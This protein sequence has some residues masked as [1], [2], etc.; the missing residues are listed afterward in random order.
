MVLTFCAVWAFM[1]GCTETIMSFVKPRFTNAD[2]VL[3]WCAGGI[4][5]F[6]SCKTMTVRVLHSDLKVI[7]V[8]LYKW[9]IPSVFWYFTH[10]FYHSFYMKHILTFYLECPCKNH[11]YTSH[12]RVLFCNILQNNKIKYLFHRGRGPSFVCVSLWFYYYFYFKQWE[13]FLLTCWTI[14]ICCECSFDLALALGGYK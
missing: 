9:Q 14:S 6:M 3:C 2:S 5:Y 13:V 11:C 12:T 10:Q 7:L 8:Q 4:L 1:T